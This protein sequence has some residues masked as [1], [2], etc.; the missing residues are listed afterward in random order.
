MVDISK[1]IIDI[2]HQKQVHAFLRYF[3]TNRKGINFG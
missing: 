1:Q 3:L 2:I